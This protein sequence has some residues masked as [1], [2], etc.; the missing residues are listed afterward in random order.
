M[1]TRKALGLMKDLEIM[2]GMAKFSMTVLGVATE[3]EV[4][5]SQQA[6]LDGP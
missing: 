5:A 1:T 3:R 6:R 2:F 4:W